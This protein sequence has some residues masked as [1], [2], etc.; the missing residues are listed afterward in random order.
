[1]AATFKQEVRLPNLSLVVRLYTGSGAPS[2]SP[3]APCIGVVE[4]DELY[5][6]TGAAWQQVLDGGSTIAMG[7]NTAAGGTGAT[8][9]DGTGATGAPSATVSVAGDAHTHA[10]GAFTGT[11]PT[12]ASAP[13][14]NGTGMTAAGQVMT[15]TDNQTVGANEL[16]GMFLVTATANSMLYIVSNAAA[17]AAPVAI[18]VAGTPV[19]DAGVYFVVRAPTP[20][21]SNAATGAPS[22]VTN[23]GSSAHTHTGPSH[24]HTGPSHTHAATGLTAT[25]TP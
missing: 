23:V 9:A 4:G 7:G 12:S 1:M 25:I 11:Q 14:I 2:D 13:H 15:S 8:G 17:A 22:A 21:G 24:T 3:A 18:T 16:Q 6:W 19:T 20:A 5:Q 10:S